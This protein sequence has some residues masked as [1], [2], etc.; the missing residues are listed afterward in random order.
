MT[1][2]CCRASS[3]STATPGAED[4]Q[5]V[6]G[7]R[8]AAAARDDG[9]H[10]QRARGRSTTTCAP[11]RCPRT[12][13]WVPATLAQFISTTALNGAERHLR[14]PADPAGRRWG[15]LRPADLRPGRS[16][17]LGTYPRLSAVAVAFGDKIAWA[18]SLDGALNDLFGGVVGRA[19][20]DQGTT[21]GDPRARRPARPRAP[22]GTPTTGRHT[23]APAPTGPT[24]TP[25]AAALRQGAQGRRGRVPGARRP[26]ERA[27]SPHTARRR[28][29]SRRPCGVDASPQAAHPRVADWTTSC[30]CI[31]S[32]RTRLAS[33]SVPWCPIWSCETDSRKV[34]VYR[35]GVEQLGSSPGS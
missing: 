25:D 24:A 30:G 16:T 6:A 2:T 34:A 27:T 18:G 21:P 5:E 12:T 15:A 29:S 33:A 14:Q 23:S 31:G 4:G 3:P 10:G 11:R 9:R 17:E 28:R 19:A 32:P 13:S 1:A 8:Q 35:R 7:L 26:C 22:T 20:G